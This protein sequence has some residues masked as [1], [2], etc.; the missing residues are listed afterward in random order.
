[1]E[2]NSSEST[3]LII[4]VEVTTKPQPT[5]SRVL[6]AWVIEKFDEEIVTADERPD[7]SF[8]VNIPYPD[9]SIYDDCVK[10]ASKFIPMA[11][12]ANPKMITSNIY[13]Q[14]AKHNPELASTHTFSLAAELDSVKILVRPRPAA[15]ATAPE[16]VSAPVSRYQSIL[17]TATQRGR[18]FPTPDVVR[19][20]LA[21][22]VPHK[23][24]LSRSVVY[25]VGSN[26]EGVDLFCRSLGLKGLVTKDQPKQEGLIRFR[27]FAEDKPDFDKSAKRGGGAPKRGGGGTSA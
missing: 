3:Q 25:T 23:E 9:D 4:N 5:C 11:C 13:P 10:H 12:L 19:D 7:G 1:M 21:A 20:N 26:K 2:E 16:A 27:I 18:A 22:A 14:I 15:K 24:G 17:D 8:L 6:V